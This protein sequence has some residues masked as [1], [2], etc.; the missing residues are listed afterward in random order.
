MWQ[1]QATRDKNLVEVKVKIG[2]T[3]CSRQ[4]HWLSLMHTWAISVIRRFHVVHFEWRTYSAL[5]LTVSLT[6]SFIFL[7]IVPTLKARWS[8]FTPHISEWAG[9]LA[10]HW[11]NSDIKKRVV[12]SWTHG[13]LGVSSSVSLMKW[14]HVKLYTRTT[15]TFSTTLMWHTP[16]ITMSRMIISEEYHQWNW[17]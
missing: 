6:I 3:L 8:E 14:F 9:N 15:E 16:R 10:I 1:E 11:V 4:N 17:C 12:P 13:L 2:S 7:H 5:D